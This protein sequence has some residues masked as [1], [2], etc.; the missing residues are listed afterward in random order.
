MA[1]ANIPNSIQ[2]N[3]SS[4]ELIANPELCYEVDIA[5]FSSSSL[6]PSIRS[7]VYLSVSRLKTL[8]PRRLSLRPN[9]MAHASPIK[10]SSSQPMLMRMRI[11]SRA[12]LIL[13]FL[14]KGK[15]RFRS[16]LTTQLMHGQ[17]NFTICCLPMTLK[18]ILELFNFWLCSGTQLLESICC[19]LLSI[20]G[21]LSLLMYTWFCLFLTM[22]LA[23]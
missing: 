18:Y 14:K 9:M 16:T 23:M 10:P 19:N 4:K 12:L 8:S 22:L 17:I 3:K 13:D 15:Q 7:A 2:A 11:K 20:S 5:A 1:S 21:F 6:M